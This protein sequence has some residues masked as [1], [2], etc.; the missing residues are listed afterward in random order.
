MGEETNSDGGCTWIQADVQAESRDKE[1]AGWGVQTWKMQSPPTPALCSQQGTH[2]SPFRPICSSPFR[3]VLVSS[4]R[5][6]IFYS[7]GIDT[8]YVYPRQVLVKSP[9]GV[10]VAVVESWQVLGDKGV[11]VISCTEE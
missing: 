9:W 4:G 2:S 1:A 6:F 3:P 10:D 11:A 5:V 7:Q 8:S